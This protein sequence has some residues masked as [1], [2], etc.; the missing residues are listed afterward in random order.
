[1]TSIVTA[2]D[3]P[4]RRI[5]PKVFADVPSQAELQAV[6][7]NRNA[8]IVWV[9]LL[10]L[11]LIA[12][13]AGAAW[14][15]LNNDLHGSQVDSLTV[16]MRERE[17]ERND[18][19][20]VAGLSNAPAIGRLDEA[21]AAWAQQKDDEIEGLED[22]VAELQDLSEYQTIHDRRVRA[23]ALHADIAALLE[24]PAR[25]TVPDRIDLSVYEEGFP[26]WKED[27]ESRLLMYVNG[28]EAERQAILD[29]EPLRTGELDDRPAEPRLP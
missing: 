17:Q 11:L 5:A 27:L 8:L 18:L 14:F 1:M 2:D 29:W 26:P 22:D 23:A 24:L 20:A 13:G 21:I 25:R 16:Q 10:L 19:I 4:R 9:I 12:G 7:K 28:L 6:R 3:Q 15:S